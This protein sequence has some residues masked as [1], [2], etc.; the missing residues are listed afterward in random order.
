MGRETD[1]RMAWSMLMRGSAKHTRQ[2]IQD[3]F[4]K[5]KARVNMGG[6]VQF[7]TANIQTVGANLPAVLKLVA[8]IMREPAFPESE[9]DQVKQ[10]ALAG[11]ESQRSQPQFVAMNGLQKHMNPYPKGDVRAVQSADEQ[12]EELKVSSLASAKRFYQEFFGGS[13]GAV[14]TLVGDFDTGEVE[15]LA[16][17]LFGDWKTPKAVERPVRRHQKAEAVNRVIETPDKANA[18]FV[19]G[20]NLPISDAD[21]DYPALMIANQVFGSGSSSRIFKRFREK[22]GWSYSAAAML[23]APTGENAGMHM[24]FAILAPQNMAR[25]EAGFREEL[26]KA[27]NEGFTAEEIHKA[28]AAWQ[29]QQAVM[30]AEDQM[31]LGQLSSNEYWGR[32]MA[33]Q[34]E[35]EKKAAAV[36]PEQANAAFRKYVTPDAVSIFKAGDFKKAAAPTS[37]SQ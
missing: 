32:T 35:L 15:K 1:A 25:L 4:D 21:A 16:R 13:A 23:N 5:L 34:A 37:S 12:V 28:K 7:G 8:E 2:Q 19:A 30:R 9:F 27:L 6:S 18:M 17:E 33:W 22:E 29:Q 31:L 14:M 3:E 20:V 36:T 24:T 10:A 11:I 26:D